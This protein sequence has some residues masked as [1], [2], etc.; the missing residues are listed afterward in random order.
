MVQKQSATKVL[1]DISFVVSSVKTAMV[2]KKLE[3]IEDSLAQAAYCN[4]Y[5]DSIQGSVDMLVDL[6]GD[7][8]LLLQPVIACLQ[9][10]N[11]VLLEAALLE[12]KR[13]GWNNHAIQANT[14]LKILGQ[15]NKTIQVCNYLFLKMAVQSILHINFSFVGGCGESESLKTVPND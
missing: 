13:C 2:S 10:G 15:K 11:Q 14:V 8:N 1:E 3:I 9:N 7:V 12:V 6:S 4:F 5:D